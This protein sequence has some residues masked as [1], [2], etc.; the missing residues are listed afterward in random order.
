[1]QAGIEIAMLGGCNNR[2]AELSP[3]NNSAAAE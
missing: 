1:M 3:K 2:T